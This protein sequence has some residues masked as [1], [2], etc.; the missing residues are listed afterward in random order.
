M[1]QHTRP[2]L[3]GRL[4]T[5]VGAIS[6]GLVVLACSTTPGA[7][8]TPTAPPTTP[9]TTSPTATPTSPP[10][11]SPTPAPPAGLDGRTF[12]STAVTKDGEPLALAADTRISLTFADSSISANAGCNTMGGTYTIDDDH[13][14]VGPMFMTEMGCDPPRMAQDQWLADFLGSR[15]LVTL[16]GND[17]VLASDET[18]ITLLDREI[19]E[20]DQ[21]LAGPTWTLESIISGDAVSSVPVGVAAALLFNA[22]GT[23]Q[24]QYGCNTG[25]GSYS[26][27]GDTITFEQMVITSMACQPPAAGVESAMLAVLNAEAI[28]YSIDADTLTLLAGDNGLQ[29]TGA[30]NLPD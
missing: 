16:A 23:V 19:A 22:D 24:V 2:A 27:E 14:V 3:P 17:L 1:E 7:S 12:L 18:T 9:P 30:L 26:T 4:I 15:P 10:T 11:A 28:T 29:F 6:L 8:P 25:G 21:P 13:L 20:P 5:V